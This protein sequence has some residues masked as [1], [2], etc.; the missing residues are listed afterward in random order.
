MNL[1]KTYCLTGLL[2]FQDRWLFLSKHLT[3]VSPPYFLVTLMG[4]DATFRGFV[5]QARSAADGSLIGTFVENST[6]IQLL[7]CSGDPDSTVRH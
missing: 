4:V 5:V 3:F 6:D 7:N 2:E 1:Y